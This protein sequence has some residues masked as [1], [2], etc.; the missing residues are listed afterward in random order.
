MRIEVDPNYFPRLT[1]WHIQRALRWISPPDLEGLELIRVIDESH[2]DPESA[3]ISSYI[4]GFPYRGMYLRRTVTRPAEV[5]LYA[6]YLYLGVPK[7]LLKRSAM[8]TVNL[9]RTLA[10]EVGHH[11][12]ATRGYIYQPWEKY[13][14]WDGVRNPYEEKM[15]D[16]YAADVMQRMLKQW[17]YQL[18]DFMARMLSRL[19]HQ[20][21]IAEYWDGKYQRAALLEFCAHN[22]NLHNEDAGQCYRHAMEKL[23]TQNP[24]TLTPEEKEWLLHKYDGTPIQ[25]ASLRRSKEF[26]THKKGKVRM[27]SRKTVKT[28]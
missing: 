3:K 5:V 21:G 4:K 23:K 27:K 22:L 20:A 13:Q 28:P 16:A 9:A 24:S 26:T 8:V 2:D 18:G 17:R 6:D 25:T 19:L 12:I 7:L 15:A 11:V 1:E 10:H 14:P